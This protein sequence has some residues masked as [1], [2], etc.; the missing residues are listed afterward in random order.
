M[1]DKAFEYQVEQTLDRIK[2]LIIVKG[3]EYRRNNNPFHNFEQG[4][5]R[6]GVTRERILDGMLLKH[7]ISIDD[8]IDDLDKNI[9]PSKATVEEKFT[10]KLI[11]TIIQKISILDKIDQQDVTS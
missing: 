5:L 7:E 2:E 10:D 11:Y 1:T 6:K 9:L 4:A 3:K 8:I